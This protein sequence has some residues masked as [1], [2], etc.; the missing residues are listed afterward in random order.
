M[1]KKIFSY[2]G[3]TVEE[4]QT[5]SVKEFAELAV[6]SVRRKIKRGFTD[7]EKIFLKKLDKKTKIKT[8][9]RDMIILPSMVGKTIGIHNGK[10]FVDILIEPE[11]VGHVLGEYSLSRKMSK[12][13]SP[14]VG[15]SRSSANQGRK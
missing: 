6:S 1:A 8:H 10:A 9:C 13:S 12:H 15:A 5:L 11:M 2:R 14:G 7:Q 3:K 4:L